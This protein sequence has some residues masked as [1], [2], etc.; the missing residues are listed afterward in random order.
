MKKYTTLYFDLDNTLLDFY[1]SEKWAIKQV[2][3]LHGLPD[4]DGTAK[5]Y[6]DINRTFWERFE[7]GEIK[8]N[9][10]FAGRFEVLLNTLGIAGDSE[11]MSQDY[12]L[13]LSCGYD[14]VEGAEPLLEYVKAQGYKVYATTNGVAKTQ[15]KRIEHSGLEGYFDAVF[16]S[17]EVGA[18]KPDPAYFEYVREHTE[19]K[20]KARILVIGD[21]QSSDILGGINAGLD[22]CWVSTES[23][24]PKYQSTYTVYSLD[25]LYSI[26]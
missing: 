19:E 12:F 7:R 5:L 14:V 21:S 26:L 25:E 24:E 2:L 16:V 13:K 10:I 15:Y 6:S 17:E 23:S 3:A 11:K 4:D 8:K 18:Q 9:E 20:D 1:R 22:T